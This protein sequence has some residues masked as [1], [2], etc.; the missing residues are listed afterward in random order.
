MHNWS[1]IMNPLL[2]CLSRH[3]RSPFESPRTHQHPAIHSIN[4]K[5]L[6]MNTATGVSTWT[7]GSFPIAETCSD[8]LTSWNNFT[9]HSSKGKLMWHGDSGHLAHLSDNHKP[10]WQY[11]IWF[12]RVCGQAAFMLMKLRTFWYKTSDAET[13]LGESIEGDYW[14]LFRVQ[15]F[16]YEY[17]F[18]NNKASWCMADPLCFAW[19]H[20]YHATLLLFEILITS[21][22]GAR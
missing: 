21:S 7:L 22:N 6:K 11:C 8:P 14:K 15:D 20:A 18:V 13:N 16:I 1:Q 3:S 17:H 12:S 2:S 9:R 5:A 19:P 10:I 4:T